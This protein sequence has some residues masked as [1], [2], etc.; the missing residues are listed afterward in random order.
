MSLVKVSDAP[1]QTPITGNQNLTPVWQRW[2][3]SLGTW[4]ANASKV[5][6]SAINCGRIGVYT[7]THTCPVGT[8][9]IQTKLKP[10]TD[11]AMMSHPLGASVL[12]KTDGVLH[13]T[14]TLNTATIYTISGAYILAT[15]ER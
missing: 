14:S 1:V 6:E 5:E 4:V 2:L 3:A 15:Q 12:L 7:A 9:T 8:S 10:L 11:T 13:V